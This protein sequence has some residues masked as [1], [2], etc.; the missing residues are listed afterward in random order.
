MATQVKLQK[1]GQTVYPQTVGDAVAV[2]G[3]TLTDYLQSLQDQILLCTIAPELLARIERLE[4][5]HTTPSPDTTP[6]PTP[7]PGQEATPD[8]EA[9]ITGTTS[10]TTTTTTTTPEPD[11][12]IDGYNYYKWYVD[13]DGVQHYYRVTPWNGVIITTPYP[14]Y[15]DYVFEDGAMVAVTTTTTS[16][17]TTTPDPTTTTTTTT[18]TSTTT[19]TT[20]AA[21][22]AKAA[23]FSDDADDDDD[24]SS[25]EKTVSDYE[26]DNI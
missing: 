15:N 8:P 9:T 10:S 5:L 13:E 18:T 17:T 22:G 6:D 4:A 7:T 3:H 26:N 19:T 24:T 1:N 21:S 14:G 23:A 16:S 11:F 20:E 25:L 2:M 12:V